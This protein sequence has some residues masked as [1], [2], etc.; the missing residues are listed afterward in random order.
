[1]RIRRFLPVACIKTDRLPYKRV[2]ALSDYLRAGGTV[3]PIKVAKTETGYE[4]RDGRH[5]LQAFK[6]M[7]REWIEV[8]YGQTERVFDNGKISKL[9]HST[10]GYEGSVVRNV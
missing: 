9:D 1:M 3:P 2:L 5:R 6:L 8:V 10:A 4:I 7:G